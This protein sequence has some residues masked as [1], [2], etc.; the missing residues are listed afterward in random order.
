MAQLAEA[1]AGSGSTAGVE[2]EAR[3]AALLARESEL[4]ATVDALQTQLEATAAGVG[5]DDDED[6]QVRHTH[7]HTHTHRI[8]ELRGAVELQ[9]PVTCWLCERRDGFRSF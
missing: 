9:P 2:L 7:T 1:R 6:R 3:M 5:S 4:L 8:L